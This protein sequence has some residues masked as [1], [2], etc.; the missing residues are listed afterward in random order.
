M[1]FHP[2][3]TPVSGYSRQP[4]ASP[5]AKRKQVSSVSPMSTQKGSPSQQRNRGINGT[6]GNQK[7]Q[8]EMKLTVPLPIPKSVLDNIRTTPQK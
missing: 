4:L 6:T 5:S 3:G 7:T 8:K 2:G 1:A